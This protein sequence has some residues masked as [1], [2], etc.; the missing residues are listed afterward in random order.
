MRSA[1][2]PSWRASASDA[3]LGQR[4]RRRPGAPVRAVRHVAVTRPLRLAWRWLAAAAGGCWA[5]TRS[6]AAVD[7]AGAGRPAVLDAA[8][9]RLAR[10]R[11][12]RERGPPP[13]VRLGEPSERRCCWRN[14][15]RAGCAGCAARRA[16][17]PRPGATATGLALDLP[18]GERRGSPPC[19]CPTPPRRPAGR[20]SRCARLGPLG[21]AGPAAMFAAPGALRV[22]PPFTSPRHLPSRLR[23]AAGARRP[24]RACGSAGQGTDST[25]CATTSRRRRALDRLAGHR[26]PAAVGAHLAARARPPRRAGARHLAHLGRPRRRRPR[27]DAAMDAALL[28]AALA[29]RAGDRVD[30]LAFDRRA[31]ARVER[32]RTGTCSRAGGR[33]G[34]GGA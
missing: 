33:D 13:Q 17:S 8:A 25:R 1:P 5:R 26:P 4:A 6:T 23:A 16:G 11:C 34:A 10:A 3:V 19:C 29:D 28:L 15:G 18:A 31:R 24:D 32:R 20:R 30:L 22:L 27:L 14:T 7:R 21:L 9:G 12:G 2:R